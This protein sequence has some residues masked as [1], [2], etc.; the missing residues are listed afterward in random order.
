MEELITNLCEGSEQSRGRPQE[1]RER[2]VD[3]EDGENSEEWG[4]SEKIEDI[5]NILCCV[6]FIFKIFCGKSY[7][8]N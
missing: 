4:R 1:T 2:E 8:R 3:E 6:R 5:D 7:T